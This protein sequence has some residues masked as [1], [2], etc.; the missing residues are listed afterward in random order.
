MY[1]L[2]LLDEIVF[3]IELQQMP[4]AHQSPSTAPT[5]KYL[6]SHH[7]LRHQIYLNWQLNLWRLL[8]QIHLKRSRS[9]YPSSKLRENERGHETLKLN[10]CFIYI[11]N[12]TALLR[13]CLQPHPDQAMTDNL[14][15]WDV[16]YHPLENGLS[17]CCSDSAFNKIEVDQMFA[18]DY[19]IYRLKVV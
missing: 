6:L 17:G 7:H 8:Y 15:Y 11:Y 14:E 2:I 19:L 4:P 1:F 16:L 18:Q 5:T 3:L 12:P 9:R 13:A 10:W